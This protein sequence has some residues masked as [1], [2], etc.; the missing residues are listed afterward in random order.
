M[1]RDELAPEIAF[2]QRFPA[3]FSRPTD[4]LIYGAGN[5]GRTFLRH[6]GATPGVRF[7]GFIDDDP[8]KSALTI[9]GL[10]VRT[11]DTLRNFTGL[12]VV[13]LADTARAERRLHDLGIQRWIYSHDFATHLAPLPADEPAMGMDH[14][15]PAPLLDAWDHLESL[16]SL[17]ADTFSRQTLRAVLRYR[18]TRR[19]SCIRPATYREYQHPLVRAESGQDVLDAGG[20]DGDT[21]ALFLQTMGDAPDAGHVHVFEPSPENARRLRDRIDRE[22]WHHRVLPIEAGVGESDGHLGFLENH[23]SPVGSRI[24]L[25]A[26][27]RVKI[28]SIDSYCRRTNLIPGLIKMDI[29]GFE[30]Q[31]LKGAA[32]TLRTHTPKLQICLYHRAS[33]LWEIPAL[34]KSL[35][36]GYRFYLGHHAPHHWSDLVLYAR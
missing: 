34:I 26:P 20:F 2:A 28:L 21:A 32:L 36:P 17:L 19:T 3:P 4:A 9:E 33:D 24:A 1:L 35:H 29:E 8:A 31:A 12:L 22:S 16:D 10:P 6:H 15:D 5:G 25:H 18:L 27:T 23:A 11:S 13:A 7:S 14:F 30:Q